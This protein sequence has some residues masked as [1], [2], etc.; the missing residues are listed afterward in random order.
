MRRSISAEILLCCAAVT[1]MPARASIWSGW[2]PSVSPTRKAASAT[3]SAVPWANT[4]LACLQCLRGDGHEGHQVV[5][6]FTVPRQRFV[7]LDRRLDHDW[8]ADTGLNVAVAPVGEIIIALVVLH[9]AP[10]VADA[11][12]RGFEFRPIA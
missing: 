1:A 4:S 12:E 3:G 9:I 10:A 8:P 6:E 2:M 7:D 5:A 11:A